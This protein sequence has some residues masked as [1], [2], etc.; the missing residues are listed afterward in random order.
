[1]RLEICIC[2]EL[3][4]DADTDTAMSGEAEQS[5]PGHKC[6]LQSQVKIYEMPQ[7]KIHSPLPKASP[8]WGSVHACLYVWRVSE[9]GLPPQSS[10]LFFVSYS[11]FAFHVLNIAHSLFFSLHLLII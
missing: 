2:N 5:E 3:S 7:R 9:G 4:G 8:Q 1:M 10:L 6:T 11:C